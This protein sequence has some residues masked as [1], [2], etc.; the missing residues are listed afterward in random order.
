MENCQCENA[1]GVQTYVRY[2]FECLPGYMKGLA[3]WERLRAIYELRWEIEPLDLSF[4]SGI[5]S[6]SRL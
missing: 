3:T 6:F 5:F 4:V 2:E 1:F